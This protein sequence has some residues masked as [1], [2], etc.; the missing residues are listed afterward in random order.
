M[1]AGDW[2]DVL[3]IYEEGLATGEATFETDP[4]SREEWD[5]RHLAPARLVAVVDGRVV[6]WA[7]LSSVSERAVYAGVAEV[8]VY[9]A[10]D[11]RG[12]GV[13][14]QLLVSLISVSEQAGIWTLQATVFPENTASVTAHEQCGFRAVGRRERIGRSGDRWRDVVLL[15]RRSSVVGTSP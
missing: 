10:A 14:G 3:R 5:A 6:A 2:L 1:A 8:S 15:E 7:A 11:T 9:V 13:G 12:R 4:P